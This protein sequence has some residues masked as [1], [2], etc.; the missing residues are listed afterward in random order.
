[1]RFSPILFLGVLGCVGESSDDDTPKTEDSAPLPSNSDPAAQI[2]SPVEGMMLR[3]GASVTFTAQV[4]DEETASDALTVVW[5]STIDGTL[6]GSTTNA[7]GVVT[8]ILA[9]GLSEGDHTLI[10]AVTD[11]D[12][13]SATDQVNVSVVD[14]GAPTV[15]ISSPTNG[16]TFDAGA[17]VQVVVQVEDESD[18]ADD[19]VLSWGGDAAAYG[20]P[21]TPDETGEASFYMTNVVAGTRTIRVTV[22]DTL[23]GTDTEEL[24]FTVIEDADDDGFTSD[25][26]CDDSDPNIYPGA[27]EICDGLDQDCDGRTDD[28]AEDALSWYADLDGDDWGNAASVTL[29]CDLP[30]GHADNGGDCN[31]TVATVNPDASEVCDTLDNDCN[32]LV[33][34]ST[35]T[36]A[37]TYYLDADSDG[38]GS[39]ATSV[40]SCGAPAGYVASSTDCDDRDSNV[41]PGEAEVCDG[42]DNNCD[43]TTDEDTAIDVVTWFRDSDTD[44]YGDSAV[45]DISCTQPS[46]YVAT[47]TDCDDTDRGV[48][49]GASETCDS[50][51]D[52][53]DGSVDESA[54]DATAYYDDDDGDGYGDA[55]AVTLSCS[56]LSGKVTNSG[57]CNDATA[58]ASPVDT[59]YCDGIDNDCDGATDEASAA[60]VDTW[61]LD[62]DSD[63]YG[64]ATASTISCNRPTGYVSVS[65]D[66]N[67]S[68]LAIRPGAT[69]VCDSVDN[70]CDGTADEDDATGA[71]TWYRDADADGYGASATTD[72]S[73]GQPTGYVATATDCDDTDRGVYPGASETCDSEDDDCDG[74][75]DES[76]TDA[77]AYYTDADGDGYGALASVTYSCS[78]VAGKVTNS[79]DCNDA[80]A[81]ASPADT[82]YCDGIDNDCDGSTDEVS[83]ADV[84]TWYQ[85]ADGDGYGLSTASTVA[86]NR[87]TGYVT[88]AGDCND[89]SLAIKP[90]ATEVCD[91][92]DNDCDG[93]TDEN[94]ASGAPTWYRD[95]DADGYGTA[96]TTQVACTVPSGYAATSTDCRD[97]DST[98]YPGAS[99]TCDSVDDDCDGVIDESATDG[100]RYY[101]DDDGDG[102]GDASS[103][104]VSCS[105]VAGKVTNSGDCNDATASA[106]PADVEYCDGIDNDCDGTTDE[107]SS[108]DADTWYRDADGDLYGATTN[109]SIA[110]TQPTG[111]VSLS[112][113]CLDSSA[114][115]YP[116]ASEVCDSLDNDCDGAT[117]EGAIDP[118]SWYRDVDADGYGNASVATTSCSQPTGYVS[119]STDC[120]D[121]S[122]AISPGDP[123][124][125]D[126]I[127]ND[128]NGTVDGGEV[129]SVL[130]WYRDNDGDGYGTATSTTS[131]TQPAGYAAVATDCND[132][133]A[134]AYPGGV[135]ICDSIDNDCDGS[136][137]E[138]VPTWYRDADGDGYGH[139]A[140][141]TTSCTQPATYVSNDDDC[142]DGSA[143]VNPG[144]NELCSSTVDDNC[145]GAI[146]ETTSTDATTW[147][148]DADGDGYGDATVSTGACTIPSGHVANTTDCDDT[149]AGVSPIAD[150]VCDGIDNDCD[151]TT[152]EGY[153][154]PGDFS[155]IS[156]AIT[157]SVDGDSICVAPGN[158][159][160]PVNFAGKNI[161]IQGAGP[162]ET[163]IDVNGGRVTMTNG[164]L[165]GVSLWGGNQSTGAALQCVTAVNTPYIEDVVFE[166]NECNSVSSCYGILY[167]TSCPLELVD[168]TFRDNTINPTAG[169]VTG[170][171]LYAGSGFSGENIVFED[172]SITAGSSM[173]G[174]LIYN[175]GTLTSSVNG[176][177]I[178]GNTVTS[179]GLLTGGLLYNTGNSQTFDDLEMSDNVIRGYGVKG[180]LMYLVGSTTTSSSPN[181]NHAYIV[182]NTVTNTYGSTGSS[183]YYTYGG[184]IYVYTNA[185]PDFMWT[186]I[187]E[188]TVTS[189]GNY[190]YGGLVGGSY[191]SSPNFIQLIVGGNNVAS[192]L[193]YGGMFRLDA[194]TTASSYGV[195]TI[196]FADIVGN[197]VTGTVYG[198]VLSGDYYSSSTYST[199]WDLDMVNIIDNTTTGTTYGSVYYDDDTTY[200]YNTDWD[201]CNVYNNTGTD[202]YNF[203]DPTGSSGN[204]GVDP[205]YTDDSLSS[206]IFWDLTLLSTSPVRNAGNPSATYNDVNGTY[207]AI[208]AYGG[209][210]GESW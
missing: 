170:G 93:T 54:T 42:D 61:Y 12:G 26:D 77:T 47:A 166:E 29:A 209:P 110:C 48:H 39:S 95:A 197:T 182:E 132:T 73:C 20:P 127:D 10:L 108:A 206:A 84:D 81:S 111:Y 151:A 104:T 208:G 57:D 199:G 141:S 101:D 189:T 204:V 119:S 109:T 88:I 2:L 150:E 116:G 70:D 201:Y 13:G 85:D 169:T 59:E 9:S 175:S 133:T 121:A 152:E 24:L 129:G 4:D 145:D 31:D 96:A 155:T 135:E 55:A 5:T 130:T 28:D 159:D 120:N 148:A 50:E 8:T 46:G 35:A 44:S 185:D 194:L 98:A 153:S 14:N 68:A 27:L 163:F 128:C 23:G 100:T 91:S 143:I 112:G 92:A 181:F 162:D 32:G 191:L 106:S 142:N 207:A 195:G 140:V 90:G 43:G 80:T 65:G 205:L 172:N 196:R 97:T 115:A 67:D 25:D 19:L 3:E 184:L 107:A 89:T 49:P 94:D 62:A 69:E 99:E 38:F 64:L 210:Y 146:N 82:E 156:A 123:E 157:A 176:L 79:G 53:C 178:E 161:T 78:A 180:G 33:D 183:S 200:S 165:I 117:D 147:Y 134:T 30:A 173:S 45:T 118:V 36:G 138:E 41:N 125:C 103:S 63:G 16:D 87:P 86:C 202:F 74:T 192:T 113:D 18:D 154:V 198:G 56:A 131:C 171:L 139:Y 174:G 126:G 7:G 137:D 179:S 51:D 83:A 21:T 193:S 58:S 122:A 17:T 167:A 190:T 6:T 60:D 114:A 136:I 187:L 177:L 72:I 22:T 164:R 40:V 203:T 75:V 144:R 1:M 186:E 34:E 188:N 66:C 52:D 168:V 158:Y 149:D 76:A 37:G 15:T 71:S 11:E 105:V 124:V 160:G 102:Y